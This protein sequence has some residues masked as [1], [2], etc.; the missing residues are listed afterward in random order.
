[1]EEPKLEF[2]RIK[3]HRIKKQYMFDGDKAPTIEKAIIAC[4]VLTDFNI[5]QELYDRLPAVY[6]EFFEPKED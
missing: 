3:Y 2:K 1:M 5:D 4:L 6:L